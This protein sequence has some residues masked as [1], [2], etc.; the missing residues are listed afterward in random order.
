MMKLY[1]YKVRWSPYS[2]AVKA[3][4]KKDAARAIRSQY[5]KAKGDFFVLF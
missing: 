1:K 3:K 5:P 4:S 2:T